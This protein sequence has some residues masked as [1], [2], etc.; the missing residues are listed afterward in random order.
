MYSDYP[1]APAV[2]ITRFVT[3]G[4]RGCATRLLIRTS[5]LPAVIP[6]QQPGSPVLL[7]S[8]RLPNDGSGHPK[9]TVAVFDAHSKCKLLHRNISARNIILE[10]DTILID[11]ELYAE[12]DSDGVARDHFVTVSMQALRLPPRTECFFMDRAL[13]SSCPVANL[14]M[15]KSVRTALKTNWSRSSGWY[16]IIVS[17]IIRN[18]VPPWLSL[19]MQSLVIGFKL[20]ST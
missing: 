15:P 14:S 3:R 1:G 9:P 16:F 17:S 10:W 4:W 13:G 19:T 18:T 5:Y 6:A 11:W 12:T 7:P 8:Y 2:G 20:T